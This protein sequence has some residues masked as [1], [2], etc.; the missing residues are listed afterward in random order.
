VE[1]GL[2]SL[3][4]NSSTHEVQRQK[5]TECDL[6]RARDEGTIFQDMVLDVVAVYY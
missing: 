1:F 6:N 4:A 3:Q 2:L 5:N